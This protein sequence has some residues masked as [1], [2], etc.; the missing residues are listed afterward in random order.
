MQLTRI[1]ELLS[2]FLSANAPGLPQ[3]ACH[4]EPGQRRGEEPASLSPTQLQSISAY[5]DLLL[6]WNSRINLTAIHDPEEIVTR[7]F[8][9]SLFAARQ[10]FPS[11]PTQRVTGQSRVALQPFSEQVDFGWRSASSAAIR[12]STSV[13]A[14][15]PEDPNSNFSANYQTAADIGSGA[16][17]PGIPIKLWKPDIKLTLI[18]SNHKKAAFLREVA[19]ALELRNVEVVTDRAESITGRPFNLVTLRAVEKMKDVLPTAAGLLKPNGRLALFVTARQ[20]EALPL[21]PALQWQTPIPVPQS[22]ARVLLIGMNH[23]ST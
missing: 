11:G 19:R 8:G 22:D 4:S 16:G 14:L 21:S 3:E 20:T 9:E 17:F 12:P 6:R 1:A 23:A 5:L 15:A 10:L 2:P 18:E 13:G 7:H